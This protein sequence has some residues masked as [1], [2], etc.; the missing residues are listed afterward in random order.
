M[1]HPPEP[2][3]PQGP[4]YARA[5]SI[6]HWPMAGL[7]LVFMGVMAA[8]YAPGVPDGLRRICGPLDWA[9]WGLFAVEYVLMLAL[10]RDRRLYV[11]THVVEALAVALPALRVL[12]AFRAARAIRLLRPAAMLAVGL[13]GLAELRVMA[14]RRGV[15]ATLGIAAIVLGVGAHLVQVAEVGA[16]P[17]FSSYADALWWALVTATTVGYGD[18][19]P[20]T[21]LGRGI[22]AVFMVLGV[23]VF[24]VVTALVAAFFVEREREDE[25][26]ELRSL[27]VTALT[28]DIRALTSPAAAPTRSHYQISKM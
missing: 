3:H 1:L 24:G 10:A 28:F 9:I 20:V 26:R 2:D 17:G 7:A 23:G 6:L 12:R 27:G 11:R 21:A 8:E 14:A 5:E 22:A 13:R 19:L 25:D 18:V 4:S 16:N 15:T